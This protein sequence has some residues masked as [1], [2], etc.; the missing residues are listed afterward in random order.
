MSEMSF[1]SLT[2]FLGKYSLLWIYYVGYDL[3]FGERYTK[4]TIRVYPNTNILVYQIVISATR[5]CLAG[6]VCRSYATR[7]LLERVHLVE[8]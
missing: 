1:V 8:V 2:A 5:V 4:E 6:S 3:V 7:D